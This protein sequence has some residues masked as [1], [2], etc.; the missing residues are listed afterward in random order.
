MKERLLTAA[1]AVLLAISV[2]LVIWQGSFTFGD[3]APTSIEQTYLFWAASTFIFLLMVTLGFMLFR[4][5]VRLYIERRANRERTGIK[6]KMVIGALVLSFLPVFFMVLFSISVLNRNLDK[7]FSRPAEQIQLDLVQIS[8]SFQRLVEENARAHGEWLARQPRMAAY[9]RTG[10]PDHEFFSSVCRQ[11]PVGPVYLELAG[12]RRLP[13]C[14]EPDDAATG[15]AIEI[16]TPV[17]EA[18]ATL[19][20]TARAPVDLLAKQRAIDRAIAEYEELRLG[21]KATRSTYLLLLALITL[22]IL[23]VATWVA[24]FLA[25]QINVPIAALLAASDEVRRGNLAY[26]V[27]V[28]AIDELASLVK[29]FN[30]MTAALER[31]ARELEQ[32]RRFIEAILDNVPTGVV[33][34]SPTGEIQRVNRALSQIFGADRVRRARRLWDLV[35]PE[36]APGIRYLMNRSRRT[37]VASQQFEFRDGGRTL[38]LGVTVSALGE[39]ESPGF[40]VVIEDTTELLRAQKSAAWREVARRVAH[41]IKNPLTPIS[42]SAQRIAR[43]VERAAA[44]NALPGDTVRILQECAATIVE[45]TESVRTLVNEFSS[46]ARFPAAQPEPADLN[47]IV[48]TGLAV[49][50]GRLPGIEITLDLAGD[51]PPVMV[52]RELFKRVIVNLVDNSAEAMRETPV[53]RLTVCTRPAGADAVELEV[54]DTGCGVSLEDKEKLFLPYFSTKEQGTGLG[55]A[56]VSQ[57]VAEHGGHIRVEDNEPSGARFII[58]IPVRNGAGAASGRRAAVRAGGPGERS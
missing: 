4:T 41:E 8:R 54:A 58:E 27:D 32:R 26:R 39:R 19:V 3:Y 9:A 45:E 52:D 2:V 24:L 29:S 56:I 51:L 50:E 55:L 53:K 15:P 5:V 30:E 28:P 20:V 31:N 33:S 43:Q 6:A 35:P 36:A 17:P 14:P 18:E 25:K 12:G 1:G 40:V 22:F 49:F 16:R 34:V 42:L 23:F 44:A 57:I 7:W 10:V 13:V 47:E 48:H 11:R 21:R 46:L 38:H 37:G